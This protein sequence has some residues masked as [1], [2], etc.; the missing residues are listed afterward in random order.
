MNN[1]KPL[2]SVTNIIP[3]NFN[4]TATTF[5]AQSSAE[6]EEKPARVRRKRKT[7]VDRKADMKIFAAV[8][9]VLFLGFLILTRYI[10]NINKPTV[11]SNEANF[12]ND[13]LYYQ[14]KTNSYHVKGE[15]VKLTMS[16]SNAGSTPK[17]LDFSDGP[18][19]D[20]IVQDRVSLF[21]T[22][23]PL[24]VWRYSKSDQAKAHTNKTVTILPNEEKLFSAQWD[25]TDN[26]G[27]RVHGDKY[28][29]TG[30]LNVSGGSRELQL[31]G[32]Y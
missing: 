28:T 4:G 31:Q 23:V 12:T 15:P 6:A 3:K 7:I 5:D 16:I 8:L 17:T 24:E 32:S 22:D 13:D 18:N 14:M 25:Q 1:P 2:G 9:A 30:I 27:N 29:I 19:F 26:N 10:V 21:F 11:G 20:F